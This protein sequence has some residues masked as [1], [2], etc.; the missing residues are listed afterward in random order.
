MPLELVIPLLAIGVHVTTA[1]G[2]IALD[3]RNVRVQRYLGFVA[4]LTA[5]LVTL[6]LFVSNPRD[7]AAR[8][9]NDVASHVLP[10]AYV[11]FALSAWYADH[12]PRR[13]VLGVALV[14]LA[15]LPISVS[16]GPWSGARVVTAYHAV[17]WT[18]GAFVIWRTR[19]GTTADVAATRRGRGRIRIALT[20]F[21]LLNVAVL[22]ID[23]RRAVPVVLPLVAS[24]AQLVALVGA[25]RYQL[26]GTARRAER[27]G[28]ERAGALVGDAAELERL[29]LLGEIG[30][31]V[32]HEVRNP[33]TGIRSLA[34]RLASDEPSDDARRQRFAALIVSEV[35]RLD[36]FVGAMLALARR[37][38]P[39]TREVPVE[40]LRVAPLFEDLQALVASR[41]ARRGVRVETRVD[42]PEVRATRGPVAQVL[43]NFLLNAIEQSPDDGAVT[44]WA[45]ASDDAV[46]LAVRD[47][48]PGV[49]ES[50]RAHLFEPFAVGTQ[51][52]GLGL[53]VARRVAESCGWRVTLDDVAGGG[54]EFALVIPDAAC[55]APQRA[56]A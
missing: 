55:A 30:A 56:S 43:L 17:L 33:L 31:V 10:L 41:A 36:R 26:Y 14:G 24:A 6:A 19:V 46:S 27:E 2:L 35:D 42:V 9:A 34:Q 39:A 49:P 44:L 20:A 4:A 7:H 47:A 40:P 1:V 22:L 11:L 28:A 53:A 16:D 38:A 45:R 52:S 25:Q 21:A 29:A 50:A 32:A 37:D 23:P 48:G 15:L 13:V 54:A 3:G 8:L 18:A 51:G 5:W 12:P